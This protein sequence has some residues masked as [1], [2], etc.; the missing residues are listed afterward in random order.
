LGG[1]GGATVAR[2]GGLAPG[3][4]GEKRVEVRVV[5]GGGRG[6]PA[7]SDFRREAGGGE[8]VQRGGSGT[9]SATGG[10]WGQR[11][12]SGGQRGRRR[13]VEEESD[14]GAEADAREEARVRHGERSRGRTFGG[15]FLVP[16]ISSIR[17]HTFVALLSVS[18]A[19]NNC[20]L[21]F[22]AFR[23]HNISKKKKEKA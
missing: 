6:T 4:D 8:V 2:G 10:G 13:A 7:T 20:S 22:Y 5:R 1:A 14:D 19:M 23:S 16:Q 15:S 18:E 12:R 17:N 3:G 11:G 9:A 21:H